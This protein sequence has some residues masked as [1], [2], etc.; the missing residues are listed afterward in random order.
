MD[1]IL[2]LLDNRTSYKAGLL[3][4]SIIISVRTSGQVGSST[5]VVTNLI[6]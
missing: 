1:D 4:C 2:T 3:V 6:K 5:R